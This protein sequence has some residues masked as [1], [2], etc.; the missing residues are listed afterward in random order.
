MLSTDSEVN[1][2]AYQQ[3]LDE[4]IESYT[5]LITNPAKELEKW[6]HYGTAAGCKLCQ[7][8]VCSPSFLATCR[9]CPLCCLCVNR[10]F[11]DLTSALGRKDIEGIELSARKRLKWIIKTAINNDYKVKEE[12]LAN[13]AHDNRYKLSLHSNPSSN[14]FSR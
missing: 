7:V 3:A 2:L 1:E 6:Q 13:Y 11:Y 4:T 8:G 14:T 5:H 10:T 12:T 9:M